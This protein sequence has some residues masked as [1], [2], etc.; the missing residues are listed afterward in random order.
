MA[1]IPVKLLYTQDSDYV[2]GT[3]TYEWTTSAAVSGIT[4]GSTS[5][6][7]I[8][9]ITFNQSS[10]NLVIA[11]DSNTNPTVDITSATDT[12]ALTVPD[13][14][15]DNIIVDV[16]ADI[17]AGPSHSEVVPI[18]KRLK[19]QFIGVSDSILT[20][21]PATLTF[22]ELEVIAGTTKS[23]GTYSVNDADGSVA[24]T[25]TIAYDKS[26]GSIT[27]SDSSIVTS[28]SA[29]DEIITSTISNLNT[30]MSDMQYKP[31]LI[32]NPST[33]SFGMQGQTISVSLKNAV[34][35][36]IRNQPQSV[37]TT[38][39]NQLQLTNSGPAPTV[40]DEHVI[41]TGNVTLGTIGLSPTTLNDSSVTFTA[42]VAL[43]RNFGNIDW[44]TPGI[45]TTGVNY[46][47][48]S[49]SNVELLNDNLS[50]SGYVPGVTITSSGSDLESIDTYGDQTINISVSS[51]P[52]L[53][54]LNPNT[55]VT[56]TFGENQELTGTTGIDYVENTANASAL[57]S[58]QIG[59]TADGDAGTTEIYALILDPTAN[60]GG[61]QINSTTNITAYAGT[62][63]ATGISANAYI[64]QGTKANL[65]TALASAFSFFPD[66]EVVSNT[67]LKISLYRAPNGTSPTLDINNNV[68]TFTKIYEQSGLAITNTATV[69]TLAVS[70]ASFTVNE[71]ADEVSLP[72]ATIIADSTGAKNITLTIT[73]TNTDTA[74]LEQ[75]RWG[76]LDSPNGSWNQSTKVWSYTGTQSQVMAETA[77]LRYQLGRNYDT[78]SVLTYQIQ[79]AGE[80]TTH[81]ENVTI[82]I[83]PTTGVRFER[84][85]I[86]ANPGY[87]ALNFG[88][89][90]YDQDWIPNSATGFTMSWWIKHTPRYLEHD[91]ATEHGGTDQQYNPEFDI[92]RWVDSSGAE[93]G[94]ISWK[95]TGLT[96][97]MSRPSLPTSNDINFNIN[98]NETTFLNFLT[99]SNTT[100]RRY[101]FSGESWY[102]GWSHNM[103]S[104]DFANQTMWMAID[105]AIYTT[106]SSEVSFSWGGS[107]TSHQAWNKFQIAREAD[108]GTLASGAPDFDYTQ[109]NNTRYCISDI[110]IV[111]SYMSPDSTNIAK[112]AFDVSTSN[113][114]PNINSGNYNSWI[115][116]TIDD[117][118]DNNQT[119]TLGTDFSNDW[120]NATNAT[121]AN[122]NTVGTGRGNKTIYHVNSSST[123]ATAT[124]IPTVFNC[125]DGPSG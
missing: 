95:G 49:T 89:I 10:A 88:Y 109:N 105:N 119:K 12:L 60:L 63:A 33:G 81:T 112:F 51:S 70:S 36:K 35:N 67:D 56:V 110:Q 23:L 106:S 7:G 22:T 90:E 3:I 92:F 98:T 43:N 54:I 29:N 46:Y 68:S 58:L 100:Y 64:V 30:V 65:N 96:F 83:I 86:T 78:D 74:G 103:I 26:I 4:G 37:S 80:S 31:T 124:Y 50:N 44:K 101:D 115:S 53:S 18:K 118:V 120:S 94:K 69:D 21:S 41:G 82:D 71:N 111:D 15:N 76:I 123:N 11:F 14:Y 40:T 38:I 116:G 125:S 113:R 57:T 75:N 52:P 72:T 79:V 16:T 121:L 107:Y 104:I 1:S 99:E 117:T 59:D 24:Y 17:V 2:R 61:I 32:T 48:L 42:N 6:S 8:D 39:D 5:A 93:E 27:Y 85:T 9:S 84:D 25:A 55:T 73:T 77:N 13:N 114:A 122:W 102:N 45:V 47:L 62:G 66:P 87:G 97:N 19:H 20:A 108:A 91:I 28:N 34:D